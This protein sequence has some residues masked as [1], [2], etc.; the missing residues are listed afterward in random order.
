MSIEKTEGTRLDG[1]PS[2]KTVSKPKKVAKPLGRPSDYTP[3]LGIE[4]CVQIA[5]GKSLRSIC[6]ADDRPSMVTI[7]TW[8]DKHPEFLNH[9]TRA[10]EQQ[11][12]ASSED[13]TEIADEVRRGLIDPQAARVAIDAYKWTASKLKPKKYGD[14]LDI[15]QNSNVTHRFQTLDDTQIDEAIKRAAIDA[16]LLPEN[17]SSDIKEDKKTN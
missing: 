9:Y 15:D 12:D 10:K 6:K 17:T 16:N 8:L 13:I 4:I 1:T 5:E 14:K 2:L 7:F 3:E 11:A